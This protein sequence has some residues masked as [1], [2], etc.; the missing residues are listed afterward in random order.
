MLDEA[1]ELLSKLAGNDDPLATIELGTRY[2]EADW[3]GVK[4]LDSDIEKARKLMDQGQ[5]LLQS[6]ANDG[7][8]EAMRMLGYTYLGLLGVFDKSLSLGEEWLVRSFEAGCHFAANDL[9]TFY[10]GSDIEKAKYYYSEAERKG[11]RVVQN[12]NLET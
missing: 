2:L 7:D 11:C 3:E 5:T 8:A 10:Q 6:L 1:F 12:E 4:I 9:C